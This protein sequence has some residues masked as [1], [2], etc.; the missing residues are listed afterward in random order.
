MSGIKRM[1]LREQNEGLKR[2]KKNLADFCRDKDAF[3]QDIG[4]DGMKCG[5]L[6]E[7]YSDLCKHYYNGHCKYRRYPAGK[8][9]QV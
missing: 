7:K 2:A 3:F 6:P 4:D 5:L 8:N 9:W 1:D